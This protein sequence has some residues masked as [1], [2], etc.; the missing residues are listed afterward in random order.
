MLDD[1]LVEAK[2][3]LHIREEF[4]F[5]TVVSRELGEFGL[6]ARLIDDTGD[7]TLRWSH[8]RDQRRVY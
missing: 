2:T 1:K 6:P 8:L 4:H 7:A 5:S 3:T